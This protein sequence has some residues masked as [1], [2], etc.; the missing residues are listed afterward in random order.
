MHAQEH[1]PPIYVAREPSEA[2]YRYDIERRRYLSMPVCVGN[3]ACPAGT[4]DKL[5]FSIF[6][7]QGCDIN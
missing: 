2:S 5:Q 7:L 1:A 3:G 6:Y 4:C